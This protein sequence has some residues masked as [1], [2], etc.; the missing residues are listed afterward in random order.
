MSRLG[1]PQ[2]SPADSRALILR[3][4]CSRAIR[5]PC[6][7]ASL[8][9]GRTF[10]CRVCSSSRSMRLRRHRSP[11]CCSCGR[12][13]ALTRGDHHRPAAIGSR[14]PIHASAVRSRGASAGR[15]KHGCAMLGPH[16]D[17]T[18]R[19]SASASQSRYRHQRR[20]P[21]QHNCRVQPSS[22]R[23]APSEGR[24]NTNESSP[25]H[26]FPS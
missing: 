11:L 25:S 6:S 5:T 18:V 16:V 15:Q 4:G 23:P 21:R 9:L 7:I 17:G 24:L 14:R 10:L 13:T 3:L 2:T 1:M 8:P 19:D 22:T 12:A 20:S 26:G